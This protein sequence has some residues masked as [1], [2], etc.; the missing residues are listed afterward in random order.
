MQVEQF[1]HIYGMLKASPD[2]HPP[3][4][5]VFEVEKPSVRRLW[6]WLTPLAAAALLLITIGLLGSVNV[7]WRDSQLTIA[8]GRN[9]PSG[10]PNQ[11]DLAMEIQRL[12]GHLA[13]LDARQQS[14]ERDAIVTASTVQLLSRGQRSPLGD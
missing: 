11:A 6:R 14:V 10:E 1:Q 7:E 13:Y 2:V 12:Q 4:N 9:I 8:F 3:R 5:I